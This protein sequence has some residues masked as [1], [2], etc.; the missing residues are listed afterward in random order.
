M[1]SDVL[2]YGASLHSRLVRSFIALIMATG[3]AIAIAFGKLPLELIRVQFTCIFPRV[4][5][6][7]VF[8]PVIASLILGLGNL[9]PSGYL[10]RIA[11]SI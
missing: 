2:G 11:I 7:S 1:L 9:S 10:S 3:A 5:Q 6:P 4:Y 8:I